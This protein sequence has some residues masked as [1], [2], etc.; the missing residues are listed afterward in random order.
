MFILWLMLCILVG[1]LA[2]HI[3]NRSGIGFFFL[4]LLL[5]PL[6]GFIIVLV[7][8]EKKENLEEY[9]KCNKYAEYIK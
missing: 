4:S 8:P 5:S 9:K 6:I 7:V 1:I 2:S 3:K